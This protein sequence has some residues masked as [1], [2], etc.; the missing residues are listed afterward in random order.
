MTGDL[1]VAVNAI[2]TEETL[3]I[4]LET[5]HSRRDLKQIYRLT[6]DIGGYVEHKR[7][8]HVRFRREDQIR[9]IIRTDIIFLREERAVVITREL[10][11]IV[12][13]LFT[14]IPVC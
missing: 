13:E 3:C 12:V 14:E 11:D 9:L 10:S 6:E 8:R 1:L 2:R 4:K 5:F 7:S